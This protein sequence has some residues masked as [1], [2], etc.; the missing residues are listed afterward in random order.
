[1]RPDRR[2]ERVRRSDFTG[3]ALLLWRTGR[4]EWQR[5][6]MPWWRELFDGV[7]CLLRRL[8][9]QRLTPLPTE[10]QEAP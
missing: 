7:L 9:P 10:R 4:A 2:A 8:R 3:S 6:P 5:R 1:M